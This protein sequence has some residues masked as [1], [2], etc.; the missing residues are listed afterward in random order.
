MIQHKYFPVNVAK[1]VL[2]NICKRLL[3]SIAV[4]IRQQMKRNLIKLKAVNVRN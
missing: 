2:K 4:M 3:M 1:S